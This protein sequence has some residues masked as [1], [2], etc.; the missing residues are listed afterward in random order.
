MGIFLSSFSK[1]NAPAYKIKQIHT[2]YPWKSSKDWPNNNLQ[3]LIYSLEH[4]DTCM[5]VHIYIILQRRLKHQRFITPA[6]WTMASACEVILN[7][8]FTVFV[9]MCLPWRNV[10]FLT[11]MNSCYSVSVLIIRAHGEEEK[12]NIAYLTICHKNTA[13]Y[14]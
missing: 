2:E 10:K 14:L 3:W 9:Q 11:V 5:H 1:S 12:I 6:F 4:Q 13:I 7:C 8:I